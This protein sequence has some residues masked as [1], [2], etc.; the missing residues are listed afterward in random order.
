MI[1]EPVST[2][3]FHNHSNEIMHNDGVFW[4]LLG[5]NSRLANKGY[6]ILRMVLGGRY[7]AS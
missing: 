4:F 7:L 3:V 2:H 5:M 1:N 6:Y